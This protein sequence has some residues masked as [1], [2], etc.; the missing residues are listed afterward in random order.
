MKL[1]MPVY[2]K[3]ERYALSIAN[4]REQAKDIV[5]DTVLTAFENFDKLN[6]E[7]AFLSYVFTIAKRMKVNQ[8]RKNSRNEEREQEVFDGKNSEEISPEDKTDI[9]LLKEA[10]DKLPEKYRVALT[11]YEFSGLTS[12]EI[13]EIQDTSVSSVKVRIH[14]ARKKLAEILGVD[15]EINNLPVEQQGGQ[16]N[17]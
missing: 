5:G 9:E 17:D 12:K 11:L 10:I 1:L 3:L 13:A 15:D 8:Y 2:K 7:Q 16:K 6:S 14:R 4:S